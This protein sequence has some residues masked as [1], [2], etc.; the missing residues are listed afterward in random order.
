MD[1]KK[2]DFKDFIVSE[3]TFGSVLMIIVVSAFGNECLTGENGAWSPETFRS[4]IRRTFGVDISDDNL[5]KLVAAISLL[6]TNNFYRSVPS[7]IASVHGLIGDGA[8]WSYE[9]PIDIDD[10]AWAMMESFILYPP[11]KEDTFDDEIAEYCNFL[12]HE[13]GV[14]IAPGVLKFAERNDLDLDQYDAYVAQEQAEVTREIEEDVGEKISR[15]LIQISELPGLSV[16]VESLKHVIIA[17]LENRQ[18]ENDFR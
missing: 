10:L 16:D 9:E 2:R 1:T 14:H 13:S 15:L 12:M 6:T 4:E 3:D 17:S 11:T 5:G 8:D 18:T 7:F